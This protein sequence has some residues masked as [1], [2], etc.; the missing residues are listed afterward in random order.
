MRAPPHRSVRNAEAETVDATLAALRAHHRLISL[1]QP[2]DA[3]W[4]PVSGALDVFTAWLN[5][6]EAADGSIESDLILWCVAEWM[7][8]P[9]ASG[10]ASSIYAIL[11]E[12]EA[13]DDCRGFLEDA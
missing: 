2:R 12:P 7:P 9:D 11:T 8:P 13:D 5:H 4:Q 10:D 1:T 6:G 3:H